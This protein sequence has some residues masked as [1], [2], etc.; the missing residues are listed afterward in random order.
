MGATAEMMLRRFGR[1][2]RATVRAIRPERELS[3][4]ISLAHLDAL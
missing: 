4:R 2:C 1:R 3:A